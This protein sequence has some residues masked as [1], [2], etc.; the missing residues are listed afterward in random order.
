MTTPRPRLLDTELFNEVA[1][2]P[3]DD[4]AAFRGFVFR[5]KAELRRNPANPVLHAAAAVALANSGQPK[6][7]RDYLESAYGLADRRDLTLMKTLALQFSE[8]GEHAM[9][10]SILVELVPY[11]KQNADLCANTLVYTL[12]TGDVSLLA[13]LEGVAPPM[14]PGSFEAMH[15]ADLRKMVSLIMN[16]GLL[17]HLEGH[18]RIVA[19][20]VN[21]MQC[22]IA[23]RAQEFSD[24]VDGIFVNH[25]ISASM[26][27]LNKISRN[28]SDDLCTYYEGRNLPPGCWVG[29][30]QPILVPIE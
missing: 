16:A 22:R 27:Q 14:I 12:L 29:V 5:V 2:T 24:D 8:V 15:L 25:Y 20:H 6:Q 30:F 7:A 4:V 3:V 21:G 28:I 11:Y 19:R 18:Q 13:S 23:L 10:R 1:H 9:A 26:D 17:E